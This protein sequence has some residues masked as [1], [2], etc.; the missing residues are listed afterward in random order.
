MSR[1]STAVRAV[2]G[3]V[4]AGG[5][6]ALVSAGGALDIPGQ[7]AAETAVRTIQVP[8]GASTMVCAG[9]PAVADAGVN[10][11]GEFAQ[12]SADSEATLQ[13]ITFPREAQPPAQAELAPAG[14]GA[15]PLDRLGEL[16]VAIGVNE[17]EPSVLTTQ[18]FAVEA[19]LAAGASIWRAVSGDLRSISASACQEPSS[20]LWLV[21]GSG[22]LGHSSTLT[23][24]NPSLTP[25][26]VSV[27]LHGPLG[28]IDAPLLNVL[29]VAPG[30]SLSVLLEA[31]AADVSALAAHVTSTGADVVATIAH[32]SIDG[33]TPRGFDI[34]TP[35]AAPTT[36]LLIPGVALT[37]SLTDQGASSPS[38]TSPGSAVRIVNPSDEVAIMSLVLVGP[39]GETSI[40][41]ADAVTISPGAVFEVS[42]SGLPEGDFAVRIDSDTAV[43]AGALLQ[44]GDAERDLTW[45]PAVTPVALA[46]GAVEGMERLVITAREDSEVTVRTW[47][48]RGEPLGE[49]VIHV[50]AGTTV[51]V[52]GAGVAAVELVSSAPV[53]AAAVY[54]ELDG[55]LLSVMPLTAD[56]NEQHAVDVLVLN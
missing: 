20:D 47:D 9:A 40:P 48:A 50:A 19:G 55:A 30:S 5:L 46:I 4:L 35:S 29:V 41:G 25:A 15:T 53:V 14:D 6:V 43:T 28:R 13:A 56:A 1:A 22:E 23:I 38:A 33:I 36:Q 37:A 24:S 17:P 34:A 16:A 32:A 12:E 52:N 10:V 2:T 44:R 11:D 49:R 18:P 27:E 7:V 39:D 45:V 3:L 26:T 8:A 31:H 51:D 42:L 21:G 54:E